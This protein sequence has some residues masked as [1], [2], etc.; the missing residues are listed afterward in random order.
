MLSKSLIQ[1]S[2]DGRGCVPSLFFD[3]KPNNGGGNNNKGDLLQK[4]P[5]MDCCTQCPQSDLRTTAMS[6]SMKQSHAM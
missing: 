2:V 5:C 1:F 4:L 3:L 6:N